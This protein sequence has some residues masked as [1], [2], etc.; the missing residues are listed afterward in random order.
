MQATDEGLTARLPEDALTRASSPQNLKSLFL[1]HR[2]TAIT[3]NTANILLT[4]EPGYIKAN[5]L[6]VRVV[7]PRGMPVADCNL[8]IDVPATAQ[9]GSAWNAVPLVDGRRTLS[10]GRNADWY[11][12]AFS[13]IIPLIVKGKGDPGILLMNLDDRC[14]L[15]NRSAVTEAELRNGLAIRTTR[16]SGAVLI[17]IGTTDGDF[18]AQMPNVPSVFWTK[19]L[20][21]TD[22]VARLEWKKIAFALAERPGIDSSISELPGVLDGPEPARNEKRTAAVK[23]FVQASTTSSVALKSEPLEAINLTQ[24]LSVIRRNGGIDPRESIGQETLLVVTGG[25]KKQSGLCDALENPATTSKSATWLMPIR[26]A[27]IVEI[28]DDA[29]AQAL[30]SARRTTK[31]VSAPVGVSLCQGKGAAANVQIYAIVAKTLQD[32]TARNAAFSFLIQE[33]SIRLKP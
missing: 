27:F 13:G 21:L 4:L 24:A 23:T 18:S 19:A 31:P 15:E 26:R 1:R 2:V 14:P 9:A 32:E 10:L 17:A 11:S 7:D 3:L 8:R 33:A 6:K 5:D 20:A 22:T 29:L 30:D 28:W 16:S 25:V 12:F